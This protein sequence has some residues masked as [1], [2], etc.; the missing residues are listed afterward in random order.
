MATLARIAGGLRVSLATLLLDRHDLHDRKVSELCDFISS[1]K[2]DELLLAE[3][4]M[5][6]I[7][8]DEKTQ[9]PSR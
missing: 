3:R 4:V 1:L 6:A 9:L 8:F 7:F 5:L 2:K